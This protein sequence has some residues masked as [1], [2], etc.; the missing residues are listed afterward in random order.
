MKSSAR[1]MSRE[2]LQRD[3][4]RRARLLSS[5]ALKRSRKLSLVA[6]YLRAH[7]RSANLSRTDV[8]RSSE[9]SPPPS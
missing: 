5:T 6:L 8:R 1:I 4:R 7:D 9:R 2:A 3:Q